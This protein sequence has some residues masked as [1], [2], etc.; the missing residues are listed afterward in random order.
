MNVLQQKAIDMALS[1]KNVFITGSAGTGKSFAIKHLHT[2]LRKSTLCSTTGIGAEIIGGSTIHSA[3]GIRLCQETLL[4]M[5]ANPYITRCFKKISI[6]IIDEISMLSYGTFEIISKLAK[7][8][9]QS[10][11]PFGGIQLII[12]GDF[13]QLPPVKERFIFESLMWGELGLETI[14]LKEIIRQSNPEFVEHLQ[15][16]RKGIVSASTQEYLLRRVITPELLLEIKRS[17]MHPTIL[18]SHT[19]DVSS[20]NS[21]KMTKLLKTQKP[22]E[23]TTIVFNPRKLRVHVPD[24]LILCTGAQV[25]LTANMDVSRGLVN[26]S[27]GVIKYFLNSTPVVEFKNGITCE[28]YMADREICKDSIFQYKYSYMP[29]LLGW[30]ITIHKSQGMS[31]DMMAID[32]S[33]CFEYGQAYVALSRAKSIENLYLFKLDISKI[34]ASPDALEF[35]E[36]LQIQE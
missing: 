1:G 36:T 6:L 15:L 5:M 32:I 26:G 9:R 23:Y 22:V 24:K 27:R 3:L 13:L 8:A 33:K 7:A 29:L 16:I 19:A 35:Y 17:K 25:I 14:E 21:S 18:F 12:S 34:K 11:L 28:V 2:K 20:F 30:A 4:K 31:I 10:Q